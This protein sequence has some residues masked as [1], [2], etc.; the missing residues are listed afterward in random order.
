MNSNKDHVNESV[1]QLF[2]RDIGQ[3]VSV[4]TRIFGFEKLDLVEDAMQV[5]LSKALSKWTFKGVPQNPKAWL[6]QVA[7][8]HMLD[9]FRRDNKSVGFE[10]EFKQTDEYARKLDFADSVYFEDE[11][12]EDQLQMIFACCHPSIPIDSQIALT[13]KTVGGFSVREIAHAFLAK[14]EATAKMITRAKKRLREN[15][16]RLEIP[17]PKKIPKRLNAVLKVVYLMFNEGYT[18]STGEELTRTDLC[19]EAIR[20]TK[21]LASHPLT[22]LPKTNALAA[23]C[24][25]QAS[26]LPA[27]KAE[28]GTL[29]V[30][31]EQDR[32]L[33]DK[34]MI[35]EGLG[36]FQN[37]ARGNEISD[38]HL[39]AEIA[40]Y[41]VLSESFDSTD[42]A[43]LISVYEELFDRKPSPI[44]ALNKAIAV[45]QVKGASAALSEL[46]RLNK[47][48]LRNYYPF[49]ITKGELLSQTDDFEAARKAYEQAIDLTDN[50]P[51][52]R[53]VR[54]KI[55]Q[56]SS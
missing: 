12:F 49:Y 5:A 11:I 47:D 20:L 39:E 34:R 44:V 52:K 30:L 54:S 31:K 32:S 56:I 21:L 33:W 22:S 17:E 35:S 37:S 45:S 53:F 7:K 23:L 50:E 26:R 9:Q 15:E 42:W 13:L 3:M 14:T 18:A 28:D 43:S 38:Y 48:Q 6:I 24:L 40:S 19:Y 10:D 4:L 16:V 55:D 25:F 51:I 27:R 2:R 36:Y 41:H 1:D 29:L 8:N 46:D